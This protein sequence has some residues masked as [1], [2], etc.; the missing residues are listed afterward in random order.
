MSPPARARFAGLPALH[1]PAVLAAIVEAAAVGDLWHDLV[2]LARLLPTEA[3]GLVWSEILAVAG[4]L[5][6][7]RV[8]AM[9]AEALDLPVA[10]LVGGLV[11]HVLAAGLLTPGLRLVAELGPGVH[12]RLAPIAAGLPADQRVAIL[13]R[14]RGLRLVRRLGPIS[15]AL[16]A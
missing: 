12:E 5:P 8:R 7:A 6:P 11:A 9:A 14:A 15:A 2:P 10:G 4:T 3:Q 13:D 1:A 16:A